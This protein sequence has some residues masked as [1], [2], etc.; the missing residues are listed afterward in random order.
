MSRQISAS[1]SR[2]TMLRRHGPEH[3]HGFQQSDGHHGNRTG[4][5]GFSGEKDGI[6]HVFGKVVSDS[7]AP[8][9]MTCELGSRWEICNYFKLHSCCRFNHATLDALAKIT[10]SQTTSIDIPLSRGST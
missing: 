10:T 8:D 2:R 1:T 4:Q 7:F 9:E 3:V 5:A 6:A